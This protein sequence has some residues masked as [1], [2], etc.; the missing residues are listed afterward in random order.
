M[1]LLPNDFAD[2]RVCDERIRAKGYDYCNVQCFC[3]MEC[4]YEFDEYGCQRGICWMK[5]VMGF[6]SLIKR[7]VSKRLI[8]K[9]VSNGSARP[10]KP[11]IGIVTRTPRSGVGIW[12]IVSTQT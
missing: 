8:S 9:I 12:L 7:P 1:P 2:Y 10:P 6:H 5:M 3:M 4:K 11:M